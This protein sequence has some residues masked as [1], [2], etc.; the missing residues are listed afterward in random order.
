[1]DD[2]LAAQFG[3]APGQ[4]L[5]VADVDEKGPAA[6]Q[7]LRVGQVIVSIDDLSTTDLMKAATAVARKEPGDKVTLGVLVEQRR[8]FFTQFR[9]ALVEVRVR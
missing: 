8:G 9:K 6:Q 7:R 5:I 1:M 2:A 3:L 4:G